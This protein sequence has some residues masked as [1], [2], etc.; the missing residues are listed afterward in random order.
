MNDVME[1]MIGKNSSQRNS[2]DVVPS[3][4]IFPFYYINRWIINIYTWKKD[5]TEFGSYLCC[6]S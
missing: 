6:S 5:K 4:H 2:S 1:T 3:P